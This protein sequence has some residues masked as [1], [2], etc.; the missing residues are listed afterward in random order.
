MKYSTAAT[1]AAALPLLLAS[2]ALARTHG[3]NRVSHL[4]GR[5]GASSLT[6]RDESC[7]CGNSI[8]GTYYPSFYDIDF[9]QSCVS[10]SKAALE[11]AGLVVND[12]WGMGTTAP[13]GTNVVGAAGNLR[14][15]GKEGLGFVVPGGQQEGGQVSGAEIMYKGPDG[16]GIVRAVVEADI[17]IDGQLGTCQSVV[18]SD[19]RP[20]LT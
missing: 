11:A 18:S 15:L 17:K 13:D 1:S 6:A 10:N 8:G 2:S 16:Q 20:S 14:Y 9:T 7:K 4:A 5:A 19:N 3:P 12:G